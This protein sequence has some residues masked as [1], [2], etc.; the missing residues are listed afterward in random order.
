MLVRARLLMVVLLAV[1]AL[2]LLVPR[3]SEAAPAPN[4]EGPDACKGNTGSVG[5]GACI[6]ASA[7]ENNSGDIARDAC[8]LTEACE[9]N[10]G[11]VRAGACI[12]VGACGA[13]TGVPREGGL[14]GRQRV[15]W[16][17]CCGR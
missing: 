15:R 14:L 10:T 13:N 8:Q 17:R 11:N 4:C 6:G 3:G 7:C 1:S 9:D 16:Q 5:P 12:G 2:L